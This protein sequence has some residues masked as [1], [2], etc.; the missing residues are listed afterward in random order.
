MKKIKYDQKLAEEINLVY[1]KR[2][3][4]AQNS[5]VGGSVDGWVSELKA[6]FRIAYNN[7]KEVTKTG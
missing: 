5:L 7:Q 6:I 2:G 3:E 1:I 4:L